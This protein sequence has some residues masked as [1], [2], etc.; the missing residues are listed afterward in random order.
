MSISGTFFGSIYAAWSAPPVSSKGG[1]SSLRTSSNE[2]P[3]A[4][5]IVGRSASVFAL[6]GLTYTVGKV[7]VESFRDVDDPINGAVGGALTGF[8]LGLSK[9]RLDIAAASG[10]VMGGL[11]LAGGIAGPKLLG[12]EEGESNMRRRRRGVEK[13]A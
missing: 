5:K 2:F 13:V 3:Q 7:G 1:F 9:K 6:A 11:V 8:M 4:F 10:L 12:G